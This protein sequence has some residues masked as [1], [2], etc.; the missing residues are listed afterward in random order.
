MRQNLPDL[1]QWITERFSDEQRA[2]L[3]EDAVKE[4]IA[5]ARGVLGATAC[6]YAGMSGPGL[7]LIFQD[8]S[9]AVLHTAD[10]AATLSEEF[11]VGI[12]TAE[13]TVRQSPR[14]GFSLGL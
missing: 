6:S 10:E 12:T 2:L 11:S 8:G 3:D 13:T 5:A 7:S 1:M 4:F 14:N 9:E